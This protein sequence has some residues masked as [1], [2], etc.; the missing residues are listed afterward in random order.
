MENFMIY[1]RIVEKEKRKLIF[2]PAKK[3]THYFE[4]CEELGCD[5]WGK[6]L[7]IKQSID[8]PLG[9]WLPGKYRFGGCSEYVQGVE[10]NAGY[11]DPLPE[12]MVC[13]ELPTTS[14]MI[15]QSQPYEEDDKR[16]MEVVTAVQE[17]IK[18]FKPE[19]CGYEW[20]REEAPRY[21]LIP[22]GERGY[23]EALPVRKIR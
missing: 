6:L 16:M 19:S 12:G 7:E 20:A 13:V 8:E 3:A 4:Y 22:L 14:Y 23:I 1:T 15:F 11:A 10:V 2:Y 17:G 5:V 9:L 21:Q 18:T